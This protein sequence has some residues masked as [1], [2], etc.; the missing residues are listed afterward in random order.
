MY[1]EYTALTYTL[2]YGKYHPQYHLYFA[3]ARL[4]PQSTGRSHTLCHTVNLNLNITGLFGCSLVYTEYTVL[5]YTLLYGKSQP[6]Y[7]LYFV[8]ARLCTQSTRRSHT[9]CYTIN[10]NLNVVVFHLENVHFYRFRHMVD[11]IL[12]GAVYWIWVF[13]L[14]C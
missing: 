3:D 10:L 6:Q 7:Y 14:D 13:G 8:D 12:S 2:S 5:A 11:I 1:T 4:C 9:L